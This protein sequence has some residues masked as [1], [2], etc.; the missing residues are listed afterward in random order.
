VGFTPLAASQSPRELV[1]MLDG[2]F[3]AFDGCAR[4]GGVEKIKTIGGR[5]RGR[6]GPARRARRPCRRGGALRAG[7]ARDSLAQYNAPIGLTT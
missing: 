6:R 1:Q 4:R 2:I 7:P 5:L 3:R